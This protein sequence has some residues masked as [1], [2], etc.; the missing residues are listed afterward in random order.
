MGSLFRFVVNKV[1]APATLPVS[2]NN[3][4]QRASSDKV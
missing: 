2:S 1:K 4:Q 3:T